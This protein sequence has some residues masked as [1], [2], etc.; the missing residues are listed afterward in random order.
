MEHIN[1]AQRFYNTVVTSGRLSFFEETTA[2]T[3]FVPIDTNCPNAVNPDDYILDPPFLGYSPGLRPGRSYTTVSGETLH[4]TWGSGGVRLVNG[5]SI[6]KANIPIKNGVM[7][8][9]DGVCTS[10]Y[11]FGDHHRS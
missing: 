2:I 11:S 6:V 1:L 3:V 5:R 4:V 9:I 7:H 10:R 8:F